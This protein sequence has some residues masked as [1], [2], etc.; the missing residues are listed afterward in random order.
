M[1]NTF[2][3]HAILLGSTL[4]AGFNY[5]I[6]KNLM[7]EFIQP[8]AIIIIRD[9][10]SVLFF[11][12]LYLIFS[13]EKIERKDMPKLML[14]AFFGTAANQLLFFEGLNHTAP[15]NASLMMTGSPIFVLVI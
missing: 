11:G 7:P 15:I 14:C 12:I 3:A 6:S 10:C 5:T 4:V 13:R 9:V 1:N 2:K 8:W